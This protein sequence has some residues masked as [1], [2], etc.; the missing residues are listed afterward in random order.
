MLARRAFLGALL[1]AG[2]GLLPGVRMAVIGRNPA[3]VMSGG[4]G[5]GYQG[6]ITDPNTGNDIFNPSLSATTVGVDADGNE[7]PVGTDMSFAQPIIRQIQTNVINGDF[8]GLPDGG[9]GSYINSDPSSDDFNEL[10]GWIWTTTGATP[11]RAY[12]EASASAGSGYRLHIVPAG[13]DGGKGVLSQFVRLPTSQGQQYRILFSAFT[14]DT[15][16][17]NT[18][19]VYWQFYKADAATAI[20]SED[21]RQMENGAEET[22]I[23]LGLVPP[24]AAYVLVRIDFEGEDCNLYEVRCATL[25]AEASL[26]LASIVL[27]AGPITTTEYLV[28]YHLITPGSFT[29]GSTYRVTAYGVASNSSGSDRALTLRCRIGTTATGGAEVAVRAPNINDGA[30]GQGFKVEFLITIRAT[31]AS[32]TAMGNGETIGGPSN[33]LNTNAF[34]S[35]ATSPATID[36]TVLNFL[37]FTA[38]TAHADASVTFTQAL[39]ECVMAA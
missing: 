5:E 1:G 29:V 32:G 15:G 11:N 7:Y 10:P 4:L 18:P 36:T 34:V 20:G 38:Q 27:D 17:S 13:N 19:V 26:G 2:A 23:D 28:A 33:P 25:P 12:V 21:S 22:R 9:V 35:N 39:I 6:R 3:E 37:A 31:G 24:T 30:S 14:D 16:T 8:S